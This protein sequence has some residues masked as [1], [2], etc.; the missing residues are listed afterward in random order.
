MYPEF[1]GEYVKKGFTL[2][3]LV[4]GLQERGYKTNVPYLSQILNGDYGLSLKMAKD[5]KN[6][7]GSSLP[8]EVLFEAKEEN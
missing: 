2:K 5:L 1:K 7:I 4:Q 6:I 3:T 8:L